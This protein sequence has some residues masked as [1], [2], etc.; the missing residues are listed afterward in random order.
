MRG[1]RYPFK[2]VNGAPEEARSEAELIASA[3]N[4]FLSQR[5]GERV[6]N[7][8]NGH[9]LDGYLFE[10]EAEVLKANM[11]RE[12]TLGL[13]K[14]EPRI[15]NVVVY[16]DYVQEGDLRYPSVEVVWEYGSQRYATTRQLNLS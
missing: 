8:S 7:K 12:L 4:Q 1:I 10:N 6:Y 11:R 5:Y 13:M 16:V 9:R 14:H 3:V 15:T 2:I